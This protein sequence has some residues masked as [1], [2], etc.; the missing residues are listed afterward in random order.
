MIYG[1]TTEEVFGMCAEAALGRDLTCPTDR[2]VARWSIDE[3]LSAYRPAAVRTVQ[4][5]LT[6]SPLRK[7]VHIRRAIADSWIARELDIMTA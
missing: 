5:Q 3:R 6:G 2:E 7:G 4:R 1:L